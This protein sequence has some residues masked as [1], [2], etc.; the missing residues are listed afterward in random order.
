MNP[1]DILKPYQKQIEEEIKKSIACFGEESQLKSGCEYALLNGGKRFRPAIVLMLAK[2]LNLN[3]DVTKAALAVEY[4]HT[5]S[6]IADDLPCMDDDDLRRN[7]PTLHKVYGE[8]TALLCSYVL[9]AAGYE[10]IAS[11]AETIKNGNYSFSN[12][13]DRLC[14]LA[15]QNASHNTGILG[16][17]GGQ[18]LDLFPKDQARSTLNEIIHK[19]TNSLFEISFV[20]GWLFG[21]GDIKKI[22]LVKQLS[23]HFGTAFQ[24]TDDLEDIAQDMENHTQVNMAVNFGKEKAFEMVENEIKSFFNVLEKLQINDHEFKQIGKLLLMQAK[25]LLE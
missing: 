16:A 2:A 6:L 12:Q 18:Y 23:A 10:Y 19:K 1:L 14:V 5:A 9:I 8:A 13:S 15:V 11:N 17:T 24:I 20:F 25:K 7:K 3:A 21:G 22:P 4:F